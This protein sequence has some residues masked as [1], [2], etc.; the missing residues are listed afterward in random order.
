M[1][2]NLRLLDSNA[3]LPGFMIEYLDL[4]GVEANT[5]SMLKG[6]TLHLHYTHVSARRGF[7]LI[8]LSERR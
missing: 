5:G 7:A 8:V 6:L 1:K 3:C 4:L 2:M